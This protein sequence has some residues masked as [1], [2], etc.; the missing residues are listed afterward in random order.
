MQFWKF[1]ITGCDN[2]SELKVWSCESWTCLQKIHFKP[3]I[4]RKI[5]TPICLKAGLDNGSGYLILSD[6]Q[7]RLLYVL[8][9][10]KDVDQSTAKLQLISEFFLQSPILSYGIVD[11]GVRKLKCSASTEDLYQL[12]DGIDTEDGGNFVAVIIRMYVV[13]PKS[14]QECRIVYQPHYSSSTS[15]LSN[16][17]D[18]VFRDGID[19][20]KSDTEESLKPNHLDL[21]APTEILNPPLNLMTP[22]SFNSP[23]PRGESVDSTVP[24]IPQQSLDPPQIKTDNGDTP[25]SSSVILG[26]DSQITED[27]ILFSQN[28]TKDNFASGGSS[29]SREVQEIMSLNSST[30]PDE[31]YENDIEIKSK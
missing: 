5:S 19:L 13:Q 2:N 18:L 30:F 10:Y 21:I 11:A 24:L 25:E 15:I 28:L 14:L 29:P 3:D 17:S 9:I 7:N 20:N 4:S 26:E 16:N 1:A 23:A 8:Q 22:D 27:M 12:Q 6:I 31:Y